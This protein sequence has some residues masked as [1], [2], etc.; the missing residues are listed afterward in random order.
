MYLPL[1][2]WT[3]RRLAV[4]AFPEALVRHLPM[5]LVDIVCLALQLSLEVVDLAQRLVQ[6]LLLLQVFLPRHL[7]VLG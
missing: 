1:S 2:G 5:N 3:R 4:V 7:V 6:L